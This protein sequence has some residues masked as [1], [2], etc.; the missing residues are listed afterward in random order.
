VA[1]FSFAAMWSAPESSVAKMNAFT[2]TACAVDVERVAGWLTRT[3][4][5]TASYS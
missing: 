3:N 1:D 2:G 4:R 5:S